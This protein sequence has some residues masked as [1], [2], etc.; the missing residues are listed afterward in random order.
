MSVAKPEELL[1]Q[2]LSCPICLQLFSEPVVLPCGHNYCLACILKV[3]NTVVCNALQS[4]P[5]CRKQYQGMECLQRNFKLCSIIEGYRAT[6]P[7]LEEDPGTR[8]QQQ[9]QQ[10]QQPP[11]QVRCDYCLDGATLAVKTCRRCEASLCP[12]HLQRHAERESFRGHALVEP[13]AGRDVRSCNTHGR[14]VEYFCSSDMTSLCAACFIEG[15]HQD[16]DIL[17]F[18]VAEKDMRRAL[19]SRK[20]VVSSRL[21][22]TESLLQRAAEDQ[23]A[24]GTQRDKLVNRAVSV[25]DNMAVLVTRYQERLSV[26]LAEEQDQR[27]QSW[28]QGVT[29]LRERQQ[30]LLE[31][32][33]N[34]TQALMETDKF[35]FIHRFLLL[36]L[37]LRELATGSAP[38]LP[39]SSG[40]LNTNRLQ[41][42]L[43][44]Q[45]FG[46]EMT[47]LLESLHVLLHPIELTFS[48]STAHPNVKLSSD[49]RTVKYSSTKQPHGEHQ[50]RFTSA[51][52][53]LC[54]QGY[55]DGEHVWVV[56]MG[57]RTMWSVGLCYKSIPRR[58]DQSRLGNNAASW[59]LQWKNKKLTATHAASNISLVHIQSPPLR[60]EVALNYEEGTLAFHSIK[61][62]REHLH[63]FKCVFREPVYPAFSIHSTTQESWITLQ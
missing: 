55:A 48:L 49:L 58:G 32:Q 33:E 12:R 63:T 35:I 15:S 2:E 5:E 23:G 27:S 24:S 56:E 43:R 61:G 21:Q 57:E 54:S 16:H 9:Q 22:V 60:V 11:L 51:P 1:A 42:G 26:L 6:A 8:S 62:H 41:T 7:A 19:E 14:P 10:Q 13:Q 59:R 31:A 40:S 29:Q 3:S 34:A 17:T 37:T 20:K 18:D 38:R 53:V 44:I 47:R 39:S 36:E 46:C 30:Q 45:D 50:E 52:Q 25:M 4:C 28:Q